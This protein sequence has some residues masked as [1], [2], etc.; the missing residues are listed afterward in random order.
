MTANGIF[1]IA[2]YSIV[3]TALGYPLGIYMARV[4]EA[5]IGAFRV[6][7]AGERWFMRLVGVDVDHKQDWK[8][9]GKSVLIFS[10]V[11]VTVLFLVLRLQGHLPL[12]PDNLPAVS[13]PIAFN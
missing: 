5:E 10:A 13:A 12:N 11:F 2:F 1:Q 8:G 4:Y 6:L 9:Y 3:L 7:G